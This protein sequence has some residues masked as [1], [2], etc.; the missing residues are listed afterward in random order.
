MQFKKLYGELIRTIERFGSERQG[1]ALLRD[2]LTYTEK[3]MITKRLAVVL[4]LDLGIPSLRISTLLKM[5][6]VTVY[7][8]SLWR[9]R[10]KYASITSLSKSRR[11]ELLEILKKIFPNNISHRKKSY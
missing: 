8:M 4:M 9:D 5:S 7:K 3:E 2:L 10:G 6:P 1:G 11:R